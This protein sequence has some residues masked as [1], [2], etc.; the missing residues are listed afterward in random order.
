MRI[1]KVQQNINCNFNFGAQLKLTGYTNDIPEDLLKIWTLKAQE[2]GKETD[3]IYIN[4]HLPS[5]PDS[6][7]KKQKREIHR[8]ERL[9]FG[10]VKLDNGKRLKP[11]IIG[12]RRFCSE[13]PR[14]EF[15]NKSFNLTK[16]SIDK[17]L[18]KLK[19]KIRK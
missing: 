3:I 5:S 10:Y 1:D 7:I 11:D 6:I 9:I 17:Y 2:I 18:K 4:L 14:D 19:L 16:K 15:L 12:F 8:M 13:C